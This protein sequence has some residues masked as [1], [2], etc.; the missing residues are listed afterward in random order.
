MG[1][2][3]AGVAQAGLS[4]CPCLTRATFT[5]LPR[6]SHWIWG[7][8]QEPQGTRN[9]T[10]GE[11]GMQ[12]A[13]RHPGPAPPGLRGADWLR[14]GGLVAG[15]GSGMSFRAEGRTRP[16]P[17]AEPAPR[18]HRA[19]PSPEPRA[20]ARTPAGTPA[21][22]GLGFLLLAALWPQE[23]AP[24]AALPHV[25][26]YEV[27]RPR[28]LPAPRAR[29][30]LP[31]HLGLYPESVSYVLGAPGRTFT[32]HLRKNRDLVGVGCTETY[33]AA[34]GS[35]VTEQLQGQDHCFYQGH[36]EGHHGSAASLSTCAG[37][38][39]FFRAGS[40]VHLIEPLDGGGEEGQ[41]A[42]YQA[43][44]LQQKAGTCGVNDSS[45][46]TILGPRVSAAFRP[47]NRP[48]PRDT[49]YVELF[50]VTDSSEFQ[51]L[52]SR[53]A[54]R[55]RVLEVVNHV[56][57]LYQ[58]L[59]FRV[60]L[61]GLE[62][63]NS[64]D[65]IRLSS[66]PEDTL[67]GFL[68]WR[69]RDLAGR[70][71][72][73]NAQ[74]ITAVDFTGTTVGL[75][76]VSSM[77]S[78]GSGAVN[79]DHSPNPVGVASTMAH[80]MGHNLGMDHD[81]NVP[82][83]Y[84]PVPQ[85]GGGC[86]MAASISSVFPRRFSHCS[87]ADLE[88]F[89]E[90]PRTACLVDA[91]DPD[92][93]VG[94]P[95]CGNGFV[96]RGE[97]CDCGPPEDCRNRCCNAST[98]LLAEGAECAHGACCQECRV[99]PAGEPCRPAKDRCDLEEHCDGQQPLCPEDAFQEN[100]TPC[101]G[102]YCYN[103][104]CPTLAQRCQ[105]LWGPGTRVAVETCYSYSISA[106]CRGG[107]P[108]NF[109]RVNKCGTL[110]CEGGQKPLER[111]SCT[112]T[113]SSGGCQA[114]V[115][116]GGAAYE[117][118]PEGTK[119]GEEQ[120]CW[121]G[122]CRD[123]HVYRSRNCSARCSHHGVCNHKDQCHCHPGWAPPYCAELLSR[124]RTASRRLLVGVL[125]PVA[126]VALLLVAAGVV[127]YRKARSSVRRRSV[128]PKTAVGL[129]NPL[130]HEG[131]TMPMKHGAPAPSAGRPAPGLSSHPSQP[132]KTTAPAVT[133]KRPPP[134]PPAAMASSP[135]PV[136]VYSQQAPRQVVKPTCAPPIPPVKPEAGGAQPGPTQGV[137]GPKVA[138]KPP[139]QRR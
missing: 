138:L 44:H 9:R 22:R 115:Q 68:A 60:V 47:R 24:R 29:R 112:L 84:C 108:L 130:F 43:Q 124:T 117:P 81:E 109:D 107:V 13:P 113:A 63:W 61:V 85:A 119:C 4:A 5:K 129:S 55:Q 125:V 53:E 89:V 77:C 26:Q 54:V 83:C 33:V 132:P 135:S 23:V 6:A 134:A 126:L 11:V 50:V 25:E 110:F 75:A 72:H 52:G 104:A 59:R 79:Q 2:A 99:Q 38:R 93:L 17:S 76:R 62:M 39:G 133:P 123:F 51:S 97:Q 56:D 16:S 27:V 82:G 120:V 42:L 74:L 137:F 78:Q 70:H 46:E 69:N 67:D 64:G 65:K 95:V 21:M 87:Q 15:R 7:T 66:Q 94:G 8:A 131:Q 57:K 41:H 80:E 18:A 19:P 103:G 49:R 12:R 101:P 98:C 31:S 45:L 100:G 116:D 34:N 32:L 14:A 30:A 118:V 73:D 122:S 1:D 105:D 128:A 127:V 10:A 111:S 90:K 36:V 121:K 71:P 58:E 48:G 40:T 114:L 92:R 35:Q 37:L 106:G 96:E 139:V 136:P 88:T 28:R 86:V 3:G 102:G 91:P 20:R